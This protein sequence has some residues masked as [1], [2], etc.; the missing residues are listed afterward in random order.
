[1]RESGY[2]NAAESEDNN[3]S[4]DGDGDGDSDGDEDDE[5]QEVQP[6]NQGLSYG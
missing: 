4:E 5:F 3:G 2:L 1:M 6:L